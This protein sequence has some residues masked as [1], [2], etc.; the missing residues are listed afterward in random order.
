MDDAVRPSECRSRLVGGFYSF[1]PTVIVGSGRLQWHYTVPPGELENWRPAAVSAHIKLGQP[2]CL[3][4]LSRLSC[5]ATCRTRIQRAEHPRH[6]EVRGG[7]CA[8]VGTPILVA[9]ARGFE[10]MHM[11]VHRAG[12]RREML[13]MRIRNG[14]GAE[15]CGGVG[16]NFTHSKSSMAP[17]SFPRAASV[18][19]CRATCP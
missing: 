14:G 3:S 18:A 7:D 11:A 15:R 13:W 4:I 6:L 8:R 1:R 19:A 10:H 5:P 17:F 9:V 12:W 16:F 2:R